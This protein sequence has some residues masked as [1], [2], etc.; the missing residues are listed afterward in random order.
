MVQLGYA[1]SSEEHAPNE[2]VRDAKRAEAAGFTFAMISDHYH[3][4]TDR[5]G[6]SPFA[7]AVIG[8]VATATSTLRLGTGVTCPTTR[9][10]PAIVAQMAATAACMMPGRFFLGVGT[11]EA[12]NEHVA[13]ARWPE[14]DVRR[15]KLE[16]AIRVI[17]LLWQGGMRSWHGKHYTVENAQIFDLPKQPTPV[18]VA[19]AGPTSAA[20]AGRIGDGF[21]GTSPK[22]DALQQFAQNGGA[23]KEMIGQITVCWAADEASAR[24]TAYEW[25]PNAA[26]PGE[27]GQELPTPSYF[28]QAA[29]LVTEERVAKEIVCGP[30][31]H[32]HL[33]EI[34]K[35]VDAGYSH[36]YVHQVGP[37]QDGFFRF[38]EREILPQLAAQPVGAARAAR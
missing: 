5:T 1:L 35:Y 19:A 7:W 4:W 36:V 32:K 23:G 2:L 33:A 10:H 30:D 9:Y 22:K 13:G 24:K 17:R 38:Y 15:E 18:F 6:H 34:E 26:I 31:P 8:G 3:P 29:K 37:D 14:T 25:W 11:G 21:I 27:L 16:E 20:L 12:L 28:E